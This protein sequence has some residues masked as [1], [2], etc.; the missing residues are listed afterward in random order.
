M[1]NED[2]DKLTEIIRC[3]CLF[4]LHYIFHF[5]ENIWF[6]I[7]CVLKALRHVVYGIIPAPKIKP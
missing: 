4:I 7:K 2:R 3:F 6:A 5:F 1:S